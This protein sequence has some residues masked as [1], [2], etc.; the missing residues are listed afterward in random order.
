ML[1]E[2]QTLSFYIA[3]YAGHLRVDIMYIH[4]LIFVFSLL[5]AHCVIQAWGINIFLI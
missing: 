2:I 3:L 1:A 5:S 4:I